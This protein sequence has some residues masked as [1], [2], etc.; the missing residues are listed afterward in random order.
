MGGVQREQA[1]LL[2]DQRRPAEPSTVAPSGGESRGEHVIPSPFRLKC[3]EPYA[4]AARTWLHSEAK[5]VDTT[6]LTPAQAAQQIAESCDAANCG[7]VDVS[8]LVV[9]Q[10]P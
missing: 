2:G 7:N 4:E 1:D 8:G 10:L 3:L 5:V 6:Q 9:A